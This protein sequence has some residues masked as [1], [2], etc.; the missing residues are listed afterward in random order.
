MDVGTGDLGR[1]LRAGEP[2]LGFPDA[3]EEAAAMLRR[4]AAAVLELA[5]DIDARVS[6]AAWHSTAADAFRDL[7]AQRRHEA[8]GAA[9][10]LDDAARLLTAHAAT[11]HERRV[12]LARLAAAATAVVSVSPE[13]RA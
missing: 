10:L 5:R 12:A 4:R 3:V 8:A 7:L 1:W 9:S 6:S 11:L 13:R 2:M